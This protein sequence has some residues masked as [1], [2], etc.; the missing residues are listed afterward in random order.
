M[1]YKVASEKELATI[2]KLLI[3]EIGIYKVVL[4]EGEMGAGKTTLIK[5]LCNYLGVIGPT[6]SPTFSIVNEYLTQNGDSIYHFDFYRIEKESEALDLGYEDYFYSGNY[7]FIEWPEKI[8]HL[9]P[10]NAIKIKIELDNDNNR[11]IYIVR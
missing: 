5:L 10:E 2:S 6:N 8:P 3:K 1:I 4:L 7:C 9:I 11:L